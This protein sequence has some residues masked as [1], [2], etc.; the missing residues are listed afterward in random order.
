MHS[1][2]TTPK[3]FPVVYLVPP[4]AL[5]TMI[6]R[7]NDQCDDHSN[8][9]YSTYAT[10]QQDHDCE[11]YQQQE[12]GVSIYQAAYQYCCNDDTH[13]FLNETLLQ[14]QQQQQ[15]RNPNSTDDVDGISDVTDEFIINVSSC[16]ISSSNGDIDIFEHWDGSFAPKSK[17]S[18]TTTTRPCFLSRPCLIRDC[19]LLQ[20]CFE[21]PRKYW[22][23]RSPHPP[24]EDRTSTD[25]C[26]HHSHTSRIHQEWFVKVC[27]SAATTVPVYWNH[28]STS[29]HGSALDTDGRVMECPMQHMTLPQYLTESGLDGDDQNINNINNNNTNC[30]NRFDRIPYL[31]DWHFQF[32][33]EQ[34]Q[35]L[36]QQQGSEFHYSLPDYLP[37]DLLNGFLLRFDPSVRPSAPLSSPL[38][39][40]DH[41]DTSSG[42]KTVEPCNNDYR[43]VYWG[44]R[45][46]S[47][48]IHTDVL[49]S[50]S[51]SY[52]V[53]GT[54]I[55]TFYL[56]P[57]STTTTTDHNTDHLDESTVITMEQRTGE[58]IIVP[59]GLRHSVTNQEETLSINHNWIT[60]GILSPV[61]QCIRTE[62]MAV[63][64]E[65]LSWDSTWTVQCFDARESMLRGCVGLNVSLFF[66]M[67]LT[68]GLDLLRKVVTLPYGD[69]DTNEIH[70]D[71][72]HIQNALQ[73]IYNDPMVCLKD[74]LTATLQNNTASD[75]A[76]QVGIKVLLVIPLVVNN[77]QN[78]HVT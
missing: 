29:T 31:K 35:H 46:S 52:N 24:P 64:Q 5:C 53:H 15:Q 71:L 12:K 8:H 70:V 19:T 65:L 77:D 20:H 45:N 34:Q 62:L 10:T 23:Q 47:T 28:C 33:Y 21:I 59:S 55:W 9:V 11:R 22:I 36:Q 66:F 26:H 76:I 63:D 18:T 17:E 56:P 14:F 50:L 40:N 60:T 72:I 3:N 44:P 49:L 2:W 48:D 16:Q 67:I 39:P 25:E 57:P 4:C 58:L 27:G 61:W 1:I 73:Q 42:S 30:D 43:F 13:R 68:R 7:T 38:T 51:W 54:K 41:G 74:R 69:V 32:W 37:Y 78:T 75:R 6:G